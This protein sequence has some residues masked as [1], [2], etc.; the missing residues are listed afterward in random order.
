[1]ELS[2]YCNNVHT[3]LTIWRARLH[4]V[5]SKM[6]HLPTSS[7]QRMFE[8][9]NALHILMGDLEDRITKL[10]TECPTEW[11]PKQK[12]S[13]INRSYFTNNF[14]DTSGVRFDYDFGG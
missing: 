12:P 1:M 6:D 5:I 4:D 11:N 7:K 3:E 9:V 8:E 14:N 13:H 10:R 2:D